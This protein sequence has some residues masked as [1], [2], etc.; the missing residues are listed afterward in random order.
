MTV[1]MP[2]PIENSEVNHGMSIGKSIMKSV[3][4][5]PIENA[6]K[7]IRR[8][9]EAKYFGAGQLARHYPEEFERI[10]RLGE[11]NI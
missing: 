7:K 4:D 6:T 10:S 8:D 1:K 5:R 2:D 11:D 9:F 3:V